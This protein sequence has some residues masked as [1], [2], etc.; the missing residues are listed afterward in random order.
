MPT[1]FVSCTLL[2]H[3]FVYD[4]FKHN[5]LSSM[6][7]DSISMRCPHSVNCQ[8]SLNCAINSLNFFVVC[9]WDVQVIKGYQKFS[10]TSKY[11]AYN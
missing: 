5:S 11:M 10:A 8:H 3:K 9:A 7:L 1:A 4:P 2:N 6:K